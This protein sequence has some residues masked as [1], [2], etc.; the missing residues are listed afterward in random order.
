ML[1]RKRA[2]G[3]WPACAGLPLRTAA[4]VSA[5]P[6]PCHAAAPS[7]AQRQAQSVR[8]LG[9]LSSGPRQAQLRAKSGCHPASGG[10]PPT[11]PQA[12]LPRLKR[13]ALALLW[14]LA[15]PRPGS[16]VGP[17][18]REKSRV[19]DPAPGPRRPLQGSFSS[20]VVSGSSVSPAP[21][22]PTARAPQGPRDAGQHE[23]EASRALTL[24]RP[25]AWAVRCREDIPQGAGGA[26]SL[27]LCPSLCSGR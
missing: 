21:G 3:A 19:T 9:E 6:G 16:C 22:A 27:N 25:S 18:R 20:E 13:S 11:P 17:K 12:P 1:L 14:C 23:G 15:L 8:W 4:P 7:G 24:G 5:S 10:L 2:G 26:S